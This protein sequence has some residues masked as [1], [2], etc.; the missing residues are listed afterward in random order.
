MTALTEYQRL[1]CL[2]IWRETAAAQRREVIVALGDATV[3]LSDSRSERALA[4]WSL[5]A[6]LRLNPGEMPALF[7]PGEEAAETL[8]IDEP[9]MVAALEKV[10]SII[11]ARRPHPGR[12]RITIMASILAGVAALGI[13][14]LPGAM[15]GH[16]AAALPFAKR[17]EIGV[18]LLNDLAR[19]GGAPCAS[20]LGDAAL[21][22]L[23]TRLF[24]EGA[25]Q[26]FVMREGVADAI[27]LPG[28]ILVMNRRL[29]EA[30]QT[31]EV[32]AGYLLA[33]RLRAE[34]SD[35][36]VALLDWAGLRATFRLLTTG[37]L[38]PEALAGYAEVLLTAPPTPLDQSALLSRFAAAG[39]GSSA[40]A[41]ALDPSGESVLALIE[42]DPH[43]T[44]APGRGMVLPD[45]DWVALQGICGD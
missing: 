19:V 37:E 34:A 43:P 4:H 20:R 30:E 27:H 1:E 14:W 22:Q 13:F 3:V 5:P 8:E 12:L 26:I 10:H 35:P 21:S 6:V 41:Y 11:E 18:G 2:G 24:G 39:V 32:A 31:P 15:T 33:E 44:G 7:A 42:A 40:Y 16:T 38:P 45:A 28:Q 29:V 25:T 23:A 17:Q 36:M 9:A